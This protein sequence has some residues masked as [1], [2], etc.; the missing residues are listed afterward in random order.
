LLRC[1]SISLMGSQFQVAS[2]LFLSDTL[3]SRLERRFKHA[4]ISCFL[5]H[6]HWPD[7]IL[8][9]PINGI[10]KSEA[11]SIVFWH[12]GHYDA[13][14]L[15]IYRRNLYGYISSLRPSTHC[16]PL[17]WILS[18]PLAVV[19]VPLLATCA[20]SAFIRQFIQVMLTVRTPSVPHTRVNT[21]SSSMQEAGLQL[22]LA[23]LQSYP[24]T[25]DVFPTA[26]NIHVPNSAHNDMYVF[27]S[28]SLHD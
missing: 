23:S 4:D 12:P 9:W 26:S 25:A 14:C 2:D 3:Y 18:S 28:A 8:E 16:T 7:P 15:G 10:K 21:Q 13:S 20:C 24:T 27:S 19:M 22:L 6:G 5:D 17:Q 1:F 11:P